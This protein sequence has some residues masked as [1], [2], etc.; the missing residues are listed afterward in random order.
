MKQLN[1]ALS[2]VLI[3]VSMFFASSALA[4]P[5][6]H[7]VPEPPPD[8]SSPEL[9]RIKS[10]E[11]RWSSTTSMFGKKDEQV[12]TEY[13]ITA[14]GSA[15]IETIFPGTQNE[16]VSVYYDDD[17]GKL[18]MTHYCMMRNR[19]Y[20]SLVESNDKDKIKLDITKVEGLKSKDDPSMGAI[21]L[22]FEDQDH[23]TSTCQSRGKTEGHQDPMTM[24]F[25]RVK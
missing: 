2:H 12:F 6:E 20:F 22:H 3:L 5:A 24:R 19:P 1:L 9:N 15:V 10:L 13:A 8:V 11:G 21:T 7:K 14:G 17:Q 18:A 25:T 4:D 16:M 23:F